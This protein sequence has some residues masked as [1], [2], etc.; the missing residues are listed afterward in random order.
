MQWSSED[1]KPCQDSGTCA[2]LPTVALPRR[3]HCPDGRGEAGTRWRSAACQRTWWTLSSS[4][5]RVCGFPWLIVNC[6]LGFRA[7]G[8]D[9]SGQN[10][11]CIYESDVARVR[12]QR[13][14]DGKNTRLNE[15]AKTAPKCSLHVQESWRS[16]R[17]QFRRESCLCLRLAV[18]WET[19]CPAPFQGETMC[20][21][22]H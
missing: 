5:F 17:V 8:R 14:E 21:A 19:G 2:T 16:A 18:T 6:Q 20:A 7:V 9:I 1:L 11:L 3:E 13:V 4:E 12:V 10:A 22:C 15:M